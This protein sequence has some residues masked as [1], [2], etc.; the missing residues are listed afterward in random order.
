MTTQSAKKPRTEVKKPAA[1][2][3]EG[4][5]SQPKKKEETTPP[6]EVSRT[7][8]S[9]IAERT[10]YL[11]KA[12]YNPRAQHNVDSWE[13]MLSH[14]NKGGTKGSVLAAELVVNG[15]HPD[16]THF[17]FVSYLER[18]GALSNEAPKK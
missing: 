11:G 18:R 6:A 14:L 16:R 5:T 9:N 15:K 4:I 1:K 7:I 2:S 13:R 8:P 17:D 3:V 12:P 10:F